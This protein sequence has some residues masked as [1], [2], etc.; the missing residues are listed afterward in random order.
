MEVVQGLKPSNYGDIRQ[1]NA[2]EHL[3]SFISSSKIL[4]RESLS[5]GKH[6]CLQGQMRSCFSIALR[7]LN[8][9]F[10]TFQGTLTH[11][12]RPHFIQ[13]TITFTRPSHSLSTEASGKHYACKCLSIFLRV[14]FCIRPCL[15]SFT[16]HPHRLPHRWRQK[17]HIN[18]LHSFNW[19]VA[20]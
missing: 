2:D 11:V 14:E 8:Q 3:F 17:V 15:I 6:S 19:W 10:Q 9:K 20:E 4:L 13:Q 5:F 16:S 12:L 18:I 7:K 1:G